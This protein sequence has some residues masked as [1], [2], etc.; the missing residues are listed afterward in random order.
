MHIGK[1][2]SSLLQLSWVLEDKL[3]TNDR[4]LLMLSAHPLVVSL[5]CLVSSM[6]DLSHW[7]VKVRFI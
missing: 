2:P 3:D 6:N 4:F 1:T 7:T 5:L